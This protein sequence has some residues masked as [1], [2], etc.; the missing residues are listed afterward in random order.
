MDQQKTIGSTQMTHYLLP[1]DMISAIAFVSICL[2]TSSRWGFEPNSPKIH[3]SSSTVN[4]SVFVSIAFLLLLGVVV[5]FLRCRHREYVSKHL[6][7]GCAHLDQVWIRNHRRVSSWPSTCR[8]TCYTDSGLDTLFSSP[9]IACMPFPT[10]DGSLQSLRSK[11]KSRTG[12]RHLKTA[13]QTY[14]RGMHLLLFPRNL[15]RYG[16]KCRNVWDRNA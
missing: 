4:T 13:T 10:N 9:G 8:P 16:K 5:D 6:H 7:A 11:D 2:K 12:S 1:V 15:Y 14:V 3:Q